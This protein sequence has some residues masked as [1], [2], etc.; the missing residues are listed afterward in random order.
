[1]SKTERFVFVATILG[2]IVNSITL[3]QWALG[4][5]YIPSSLGMIANPFVI[6]IISAP[7]ILVTLVILLYFIL[8][9]VENRWIEYGQV[10]PKK[11]MQDMVYWI[12]GMLWIPVSVLWGIA[13][14]R[15]FWN[16]YDLSLDAGEVFPMPMALIS[17]ITL[18]YF[19]FVPA[20]F[21]YLAH[22]TVTIRRFLSPTTPYNILYE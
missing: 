10:P 6:A 16:Y 14:L 4:F 8:R 18:M 13:I 5:A 21:A 2:F 7:F 3:L 11:V 20:L 17:V 12:A 19:L 22:I 1:M 15:V 9:S